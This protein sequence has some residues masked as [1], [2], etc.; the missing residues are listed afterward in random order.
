[1]LLAIPYYRISKKGRG[2]RGLG[3]AAQRYLVRSFA[4]YN[5]FR[6][7]KEFIEIESVRRKN[8]PQLNLALEE[9]RKKGAILLIA[10]Q[11]RLS[12]KVTFISMLIDSGVPYLALD[13]PTKNKF[14][15]QIHA[16]FAEKEHDEISDRT[17]KALQAAKRKGVVLGRF[18]IEVLSKRNIRKSKAFARK[19]NPLIK[20]L[21]RE[22]YK[23]VRKIMEELNRRKIPPFKGKK[24][25]WHITTVHNLLKR[26]DSL[27]IK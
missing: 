5:N 13:N 26:I 6:L 10:K 9:C 22:G 3:L 25:K 17:K 14:I 11:D 15:A 16:A 1:M 8:R 12:R 4:R 20:R 21:K 27:T 7:G 23:T 18:A 2:E 24:K 19:M